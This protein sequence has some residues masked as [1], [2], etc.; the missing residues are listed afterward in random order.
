MEAIDAGGTTTV[1]WSRGLRTPEHADAAVDALQE[2]P[3]R[4]VLAWGN[5][6]A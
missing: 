2:V 6:H 3:G 5:I 4:F 1:D